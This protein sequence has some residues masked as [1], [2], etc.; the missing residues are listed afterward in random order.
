MIVLDTNI[1]SDSLRSRPEPKVAAWLNRQDATQLFTTAVCLGEMLY[2][3]SL[4]P[5]G[6][7][8]AELRT[9]VE[10][11]L[12]AGF[13]GR[14]LDYDTLAARSYASLTARRQLAGRRMPTADAQIA[15][16]CQV[17]GAQLATRNVADF[18]DA[19]IA[20]VNPWDAADSA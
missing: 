17:H 9:R 12:T 7:R 4:L 10:D 8:Q 11:L 3:V 5:R 19:G 16:I 2:G 6:R 1:L 15:A 13:R 18:A 14:I 20:L